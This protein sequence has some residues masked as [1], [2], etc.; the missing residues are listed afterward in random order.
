MTYKQRLEEVAPEVMSRPWF[1]LSL[2][3][4][5]FSKTAASVWGISLVDIKSET[6]YSKYF[7]EPTDEN[8]AFDNVVPWK[9]E[10]M[11]SLSDVAFELVD[12]LGSSKPVLVTY[13]VTDW[14]LPLWQ[15]M[16]D[17]CPILTNIGA[18]LLDLKSVYYSIMIQEHR[19]YEGSDEPYRMFLKQKLGRKFGLF[20]MADRFELSI[21]AAGM[22][23]DQPTAKAM[24]SKKILEHLLYQKYPEDKDSENSSE[25]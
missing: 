7:G 3:T 2:A 18:S 22:P 12:L 15:S 24:L 20:A 25:A 6:K 13:N 9:V 21:N 23:P 8:L 14:M 11:T 19:I 17:T 10:G 1:S 4:R 16:C 5:D